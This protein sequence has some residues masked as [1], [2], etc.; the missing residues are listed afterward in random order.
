VGERADMVERHAA[1]ALDKLVTEAAL[2]GARLAGDQDDRRSTRLRL[3]QSLREQSEL[4]LAAGEAREAASPGALEAGS[5]TRT[6]ALAP[7]RLCS[8]RSR[9]SKK[10]AARRAVCSVTVM[11]PGGA[12]CC[13]RAASPT[14]WRCAV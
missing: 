7:L 10:P 9:K 8:P 13:T 4:A 14:T 5:N 3:A 11:P 12:S 1:G 6:G 2:S